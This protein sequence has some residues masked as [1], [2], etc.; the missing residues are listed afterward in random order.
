MLFCGTPSYT[1]TRCG[2]SGAGG[3]HRTWSG[4]G[5]G[6]SPPPPLK[7]SS[8]RWRDLI[9]RVL[10][11]DPLRSPGCQSP[12]RATAV[13][14]DPGVV[15]K[16]LRHL[17][18]WHDTP[19]GLSPPGATVPYNYEPCGD[20]HPMPNYENVLTDSEAPVGRP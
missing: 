10:L 15:E 19:A 6:I 1:A 20:V 2:A 17:C 18:A 16:I 12:R 4:G 13:I 9:L 5:P 14:G 11:V 7:L 8:K 3:C